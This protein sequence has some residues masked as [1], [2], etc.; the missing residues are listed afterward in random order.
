MAGA[1]FQSAVD[2]DGM[3]C[4]NTVSGP[5]GAGQATHHLGPLQ[6]MQRDNLEADFLDYARGKVLAPAIILGV[7]SG[8]CIGLLLLALAFDAWFV[9]SG[10]AGRAAQARGDSMEMAVAVRILWSVLMLAANAV[11]LAGAMRMKD[12]RNPGLA[13]GAC[14]LALI[15]C[16]GPCFVLGIPFGIWGLVALADANVRAAFES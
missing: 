7:L 8:I 10:T 3:A 1:N 6:S 13:R 14:I 4:S 5:A 2:P 11:I 16:L 12:L 15:P 9:L